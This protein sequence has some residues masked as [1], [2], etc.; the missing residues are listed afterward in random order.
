M[1]GVIVILVYV[2][3]VL[4][5]AAC[6]KQRRIRSDLSLHSSHPASSLAPVSTMRLDIPVET[7]NVIKMA[8]TMTFRGWP[9]AKPPHFPMNASNDD[10][11]VQEGGCIWE[12]RGLRRNPGTAVLIVI[13]HC[14]EMERTA[15]HSVRTLRLRSS[16]KNL[17]NT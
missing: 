15:L 11:D 14:Q 6:L 5:N 16:P 12:R 17:G 2:R 3:T 9:S 4:D 7:S 1:L 8:N 10:C 13:M